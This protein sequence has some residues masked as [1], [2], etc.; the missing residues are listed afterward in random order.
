VYGGGPRQAVL[1]GSQF[2]LSVNTL[3]KLIQF[4]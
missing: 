1:I 2:L 3:K 4:K